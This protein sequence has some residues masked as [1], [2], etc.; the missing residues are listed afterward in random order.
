MKKQS[1][2]FTVVNNTEMQPPTLLS[3]KPLPSGWKEACYQEDPKSC[4][5]FRKEN[6]VDM[7]P[8][9]LELAQNAH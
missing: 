9:S 7:R 4:L 1:V 8:T 6:C 3:H 5:K 2:L